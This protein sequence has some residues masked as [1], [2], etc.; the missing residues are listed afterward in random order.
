MDKHTKHVAAKEMMRRV[1]KLAI[2]AI[3][4][5]F[6]VK[7]ATAAIGSITQTE[8]YLV[9]RLSDIQ[10]AEDGYIVRSTAG[11]ISVYYRGTGYP[12]FVTGIALETLTDADKEDIVSGIIVDTRE[13]LVKLMED[14]GS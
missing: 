4:L 5:I 12:A 6:A 13:Q 2:L 9:T 14:L 10:E 3:V 7:T 1:V 8:H 11:F